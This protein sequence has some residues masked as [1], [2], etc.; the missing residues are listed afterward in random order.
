[1]P[2]QISLWHVA[3]QIFKNLIASKIQIFHSG[4]FFFF[5]QF[6]YHFLFQRTN[7]PL[8]M[9]R[10]PVVRDLVGVFRVYR[11]F[12]RTDLCLTAAAHLSQQWR[13]AWMW[14]TVVPTNLK[15]RPKGTGF[16][17]S[18]LYSQELIEREE[19]HY[20]LSVCCES[21][22]LTHRRSI[23]TECERQWF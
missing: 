7:M 3:S 10:H 17:I 13:H 22:L 9:A 5:L 6:S 1:M 19:I 12:P 2:F 8:V 4:V 18:A 15:S 21:F 11:G 16:C 14:V 23:M 20:F